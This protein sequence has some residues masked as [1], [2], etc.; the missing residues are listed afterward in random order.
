M[1][2]RRKFNGAKLYTEAWDAGCYLSFYQERINRK[3]LA[4]G[5]RGTEKEKETKAGRQIIAQGKTED[6]DLN[7]NLRGRR[8]FCT[9]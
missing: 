4:T 3:I 1:T 8:A 7:N 2:L 9:R 6:E 5:P